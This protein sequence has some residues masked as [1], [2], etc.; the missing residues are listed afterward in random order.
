MPGAVHDRHAGPAQVDGDE[1][2]ALRGAG[3]DEGVGQ[4]AGQGAPGFAAGEAAGGEVEA[5]AGVLGGE[6]AP[7]RPLGHRAT[8]LGEDRHGVQVGLDDAGGGE[9]ALG[10]GGQHLPAAPGAAGAGEGDLAGQVPGQGERA[11]DR[12]GDGGG[13]GTSEHDGAPAAISTG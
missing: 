8:G 5:G 7:R 3:G 9:V 12:W 10:E 1:P 11:V 13:H 2:A 4:A 6:H